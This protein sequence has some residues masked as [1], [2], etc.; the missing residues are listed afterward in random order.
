M[1]FLNMGKII[2]APHKETVEGPLIFLAGPIHGAPDWQSE[3]IGFLGVNPSLY[4]A[5]PRR[6]V[7][8]ENNLTGNEKFTQIAW[9][10]FYLN[11]AARTGVTLFWLPKPLDTT[12]R[13]YSETSRFEL[14]EAVARHYLQKIRLVVGIESGF[15][16][17][18][19]LRLTL[20]TKAPDVP[21]VGNL[22]EACERALLL[23]SPYE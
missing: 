23:L 16:D 14:G 18:E 2:I 10:H 1:S 17:E 12:L 3:A 5:S 4:I 13:S 9:E 20:A 6:V 22:E 21:I 11:Q 8:G 15:S 7:E 19:Y